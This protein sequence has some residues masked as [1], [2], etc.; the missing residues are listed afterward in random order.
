MGGDQ[1][2]NVLATVQKDN[3]AARGKAPWTAEE[4]AAFKVLVVMV[5]AVTA[6]VIL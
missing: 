6:L 5:A 4:E 1:A 3:L 2:A